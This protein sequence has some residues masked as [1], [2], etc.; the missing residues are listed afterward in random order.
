VQIFCSLEVANIEIANHEFFVPKKASQRIGSEN[1]Y[2]F[3][4]IDLD[5]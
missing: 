5:I 1:K 3:I 4:N 2:M